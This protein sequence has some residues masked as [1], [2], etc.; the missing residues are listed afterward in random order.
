MHQRGPKSGYEG[1]LEEDLLD[2]HARGRVAAPSIVSFDDVVRL[3]VARSSGHSDGLPVL[4]RVMS[5][6][7]TEMDGKCLPLNSCYPL[8]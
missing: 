3:A 4:N 5:K 8:N 7:L 6:L 1:E 2:K